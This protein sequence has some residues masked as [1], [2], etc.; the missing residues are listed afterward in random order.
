L[1]SAYELPAGHDTVAQL[2]DALDR[3]G[4]RVSV[5]HEL[6]RLPEE[7]DAAGRAGRD[8]GTWVERHGAR[9]R[10]EELRNL[11][12]QFA[13][14][15]VLP[16]RDQARTNALYALSRSAALAV[17]SLVPLIGQ[18]RSS[19]ITIALAMVIVQA[20]DAVVGATIR[21]RMK[22]FGPASLGALNLVTLVWLLAS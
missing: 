16:A 4:D 15:R 19:L 22:T 11:R 12:R 7:A 18:T 1:V 6:L 9:Q 8:D 10:L 21:D 3:R 5:L 2:T 17:V 13:G 20:L 14:V